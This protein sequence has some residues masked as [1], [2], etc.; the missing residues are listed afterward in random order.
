MMILSAINYIHI[1]LNIL[2][3]NSNYFWLFILHSRLVAVHLSPIT[4]TIP[5]IYAFLY[6]PFDLFSFLLPIKHI[7]SS[8]LALLICPM[9]CILYFLIV[10]TTSLSV[11]ASSSTS[12]FLFLAA[13]FSTTT[14]PLLPVWAY[15][16]SVLSTPHIYTEILTTQM[17][18]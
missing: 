2:S 17:F 3:W 14:F 9:N 1:S 6:Q 11:F 8:S 16:A 15:P 18:E 13:F 5:F 12:S 10:L 4:S 7:S